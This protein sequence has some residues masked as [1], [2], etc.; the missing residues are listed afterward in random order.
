MKTPTTREDMQKLAQEVRM[1]RNIKAAQTHEQY[2]ILSRYA[3]TYELQSPKGF[4]YAVD[5]AHGNCDCGD[6]TAALYRLNIRLHQHNIERVE[7]KHIAIIRHIEAAQQRQ[8]K[9][10]TIGEIMTAARYHRQDP[11]DYAQQQNLPPQLLRRVAAA[12][13]INSHVR[14]RRVSV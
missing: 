5:M 3:D 4:T 6:A 14:P 2:T 12:V 7:C 10:P 8:V 13:E 1:S 11:L 9:L